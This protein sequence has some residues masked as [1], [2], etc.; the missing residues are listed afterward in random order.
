MEVEKI[1]KTRKGERRGKMQK[2]R[3]E[4]DPVGVKLE[5]RFVKEDKKS[6]RAKVMW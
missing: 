3:R 2:N 6:E 5:V 1:E 4:K